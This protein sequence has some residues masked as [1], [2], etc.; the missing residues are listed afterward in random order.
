MILTLTLS[1]VSTYLRPQL[2]GG[3]EDEDPGEAL[4]AGGL[5]QQALQDGQ[6]VRRR[7]TRTRRRA[8]TYVL[9]WGVSVMLC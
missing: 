1:G 7:L 9:A 3:H 5:V 2:P 8:R 6:H 4:P